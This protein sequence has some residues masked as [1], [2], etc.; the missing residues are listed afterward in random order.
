MSVTTDAEVPIEDYLCLALWKASRS[1][2]SLY[3]DLLDE[4][5]LTYPQYLVMRLLWQKGPQP[6]KVIASVLQLDYGTLSPLLKRLE[7]AGLVTRCRR[8]DDERSVEI[9]LTDAGEALRAKADDVPTRLICAMG[10]D[11]QTRAQLLQMLRQLTE[12]VSAAAE[13]GDRGEQPAKK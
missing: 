11:E 12:T 2:T 5:G 4:L 10:L 13:S 6:V 8:R 7:A 1:M 3:R 9:G